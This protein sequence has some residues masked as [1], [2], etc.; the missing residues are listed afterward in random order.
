MKLHFLS[1]FILVTFFV[2][3]VA[4]QNFQPR[5]ARHSG[6]EPATQSTAVSAD[7]TQLYSQ[8]KA[9]GTEASVTAIARACSEVIS[10]T[11][12]SQVDRDYAA[13]LLAWALNRRG[14]MRSEQAAKLV[15][16]GEVNSA[17]KLDNL[18]A[19]DFATAIEFGPC[20]WRTCHNYAIS[21]AMKGEY[22]RAIEQL[23]R[24]IELKPD[25]PNAHFNRGELY[26]EIQDFPAA[27]RDYTSAI[28]LNDK[29]PQFYNS[30]GH[31]R[32]MLKSYDQAMS[33]Y[34]RA[35]ELAGDSAVYYT[36]LADA[37]QF[38]GQWEEAATAYRSAVAINNQ[39]ARA[40][41]NAAWLMATCPDNKLQNFELALSAARKAIELGEG[42]TPQT[43][44]TLAAATAAAGR[45]AEAA[46]L[47]RQALEMTSDAEE[48]IELTQR[49]QLYEQGQ[50][51][52]QPRPLTAASTR[53]RT[54]SGAAPVESAR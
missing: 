44:D 9:A 50:A 6:Q 31:C 14:E 24:A 39:Y 20:S 30:R 36:D 33:D 34:R 42:R 19:D 29:D 26:F 5:G 16:Q 7:L 13:S 48:R 2:N 8:T 49:L 17:A 38:L 40:F 43:L 15:E 25:Y 53:I 41:Q 23:T 1:A 18:A 11:K 21:L 51:Y 46:K 12:R 35:A 52:V 32:F 54:A 22:R 27:M 4:A 28:E 37:H 10:S 45:H 47:Q 3:V